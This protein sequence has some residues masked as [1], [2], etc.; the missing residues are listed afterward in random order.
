MTMR[1]KFIAVSMATFMAVCVHAPARAA[2]GDDIARLESAISQ[3]ASYKLEKPE[4]NLTVVEEFVTRAGN[5]T[6][7]CPEVEKRLAAVLQS[8]ATSDCK[9]F[10]CRQLRV[11]G[12]AHS[13]PAL[14][15]LLPDAKMSHM[16]RYA[17]EA[18]PGPESLA[19]LREAVSKTDG[20]TR[21][22]IINSLGVRRDREAVGQLIE[23]LR[24]Q[25]PATADAAAS[26][27]GLIGGEDVPGALA[28]ARR[29]DNVLL[30]HSATDALLKCGDIAFSE[31]R[32]DEAA[33]IYEKLYADWEPRTVRIAALRGILTCRGEDG[34]PLALEALK[35]NDPQLQSVV[36]E[37]IRNLKGGKITAA[38]ADA[39]PGAEPITQVMLLT[40]LAE[41]GDAAARPCAVACL[42]SKN[43][44]V[45]AAAVRALAVLGDASVIPLLGKLAVTAAGD[46]A[47]ALKLTLASL[48]GKD[49]NKALVAA[50]EGA[51]ADARALFC[52]ALS[53]RMAVEETPALLRLA[54]EDKEGSVRLAA[55]DALVP[56]VQAGDAQ[57]LAGILTAAKSKE[58]Q[59]RAEKSLLISTRKIEAAGRS[60][61]VIALISNVKNPTPAVICALLRVLAD[62]ADEKAL[63]VVQRQM[64]KDSGDEIRDA[65]VR[66]LADWPNEA[67]SDD[68]LK[69]AHN[70]GNPV[71]GVL[72]L[73]GFS[74]MAALTAAKSPDKSDAMFAEALQLAAKPEDR[75]FIMA[76]MKD[77]ASVTA[78][79]AAD[80]L[81]KDEANR[82]EAELAIIAVAKP[83]SGRYKAEAVA[84]A[85]KLMEVSK[86]EDVKKQAAEIIADIEKNAD[87]LT[88]WEAS[89]PYKREQAGPTDLFRFSFPPEEGDGSGAAWK[90]AVK[91]VGTCFIDLKLVLQDAD[92]CAG[93]LRTM[94]KSPAE[95]DAVLEVGSDDGAAVWLN[96]IPVIASNTLR[97]PEP[98]QDKAPVRLKQGWN[99]LLV[100]VTQGSG[101]WSFCARFVKPDG[102]RLE[103]LEF[104]T[105][106]PPETK[107]A[108][109]MLESTPIEFMGD[110]QGQCK[111][112]DGSER[113][114]VC[115]VIAYAP[116]MYQANVLN[117]FARRCEAVVV[118]KG[119]FD[120]EKVPVYGVGDKDGF[121]GIVWKG[122]ISKE[123]FSGSLSGKAT[124]SFD[125]KPV[126]RS[127][128]T[129][130]MPPPAGAIV[131]FDGKSLDE[132]QQPDGQPARWKLVDGAMEV[133][134]GTGSIISKKQ[135]GDQKVHVEFRSP[136]MPDCAGQ[137]RGN[138]GVYLQGQF[139]VQVLDSYGLY[140]YDNECGGIYKV[141]EPLVNM[142]FPPTQW[143]TYDIE[144]TAPRYDAGGNRTED[145][146]ITVFHNGVKIHENIKVGGTTTAG[147]GGALSPRG[148]LY[149]QDHGN[150]VQY[151]NIWAVEIGGK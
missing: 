96:A 105:A 130:N 107:M 42:Q 87:Y 46:E 23:L 40:A 140:G 86:N 77:S 108:M 118:L 54:A 82:A 127:S 124:G 21:I 70:P 109:G 63:A 26:S 121:F 120:G 65:A 126:K 43:A 84:A 79:R 114:V 71:Q 89:G 122:T 81:L 78:L 39:V 91:G 61:A 67:P 16:A 66:I 95:Q 102:G 139:E 33:A 135:F 132:W 97:S 85:R 10:V 4:P 20:A 56:L 38:M 150:T 19:A 137:A 142:C 36:L 11:I 13:V 52:R 15:A 12:A 8:E 149:L 80:V 3:L 35:G 5:D 74:R 113:K 17:L 90:P 27:L 76:G 117:E 28:V 123:R 41:R 88:V 119:R 151:R 31:G 147:M 125:L 50:C 98:G 59:R 45:R 60:D 55:L 1:M 148:G 37:R 145:A 94:V 115:Q 111:F 75:K 73:R 116:G 112:A 51:D 7:L 136:Y 14:A 141:A 58:E 22:G 106:P 47:D 34:M 68:L 30:R 18:I 62:V 83:L 57:T 128:P 64:G 72:A 100:K 25:D 99:S 133:V 9:E 32:K 104:N 131:L 53:A 2:E 92:N 69:I 49:V 129:M 24:D 144:F 143:Q 103:G 93:Y 44:G 101:G 110:W 138:S 29:T 6:A 48:R 146:R 134:P